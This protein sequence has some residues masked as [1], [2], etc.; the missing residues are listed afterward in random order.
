M[1]KPA[2]AYRRGAPLLV[3]ALVGLATKALAQSPPAALPPP[4]PLTATPTSPA[5]PPTTAPPPAAPPTAAPTS[6]A[7]PPSVATPPARPSTATPTPLAAPTSQAAPTGPAAAPTLAHATPAAPA[8]TLAPSSEDAARAVWLRDQGNKAFDAARYLDAAVAYEAAAKLA[9]DPPLF[10]LLAQ[11]YENT[12]RHAEALTSY[13]RFKDSASP[14]ALA[15]VPDLGKRMAIMRNKVTVLR[16]NVN[17]PGARVRV[18]DALVGVKQ[19]DRPVVASLDEGKA[20]IEISLD[21]YQ[22][23]YKEYSLLGGNLLELD[24]NLNRSAAAI[25][26]VEKTKTVYVTAT[27]F[28]SQWWF[29]AG[30][31]VLV[32]GGATTVYALSTEKDPRGGTLGV[33]PGPLR[34]SVGATG[35]HF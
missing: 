11:A 4:P 16:V 25:T 14:A 31:S 22:P 3:L 2:L 29:W 23:Y 12:G 33:I 13:A 32:V 5:A 7:G 15:R 6:P 19:A 1:T 27:P 30:A 21:G 18:R 8:A 26:V 17:V 10:F 35:L 28:W 34:V 24:V 20:P 9:P